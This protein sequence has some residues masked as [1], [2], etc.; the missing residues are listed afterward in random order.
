MTCALLLASV[1]AGAPGGE[2]EAMFGMKKWKALGWRRLYRLGV[3][4]G[5]AFSSVAKLL[6]LSQFLWASTS[7]FG[8]EESYALGPEDRLFCRFVFEM[9]FG[10]CC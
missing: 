8:F 4:V 1:S 3:G 9:K 6:M 7:E 10:G 2:V 5:Y